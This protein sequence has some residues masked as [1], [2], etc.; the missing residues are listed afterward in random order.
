MASELRFALGGEH[1]LSSLSWKVWAH[2]PDAYIA[3]RD[4][5]KEL[6]VSLHGERWRVGVTGE[7]AAA[8]AHLRRPGQDRAW[9]VWDRPAPEDGVTVGYRLLFFPSESTLTPAMRAGLKWR[10]VEFVGVP[11]RDWITVVTIS[12]NEPGVVMAVDGAGDQAAALLDMPAGRR[13]QVS[14]HTEI[15]GSDFRDA[16]AQGY[17][18]TLQ[19]MSEEGVPV[20]ADGR[21]FVTGM[22]GAD[23][24]ACELN[25]TRPSPDPFQLN[26]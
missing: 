3:C 7:K 15:L 20:V 12:I 13:L 14:F 26:S 21:L 8:T 11:A 19:H 25:V 2:G 10:G 5:Y 24:F 1:G 4:N 18:T 6:K 22:R 9:M 16:V 23:H 17:R